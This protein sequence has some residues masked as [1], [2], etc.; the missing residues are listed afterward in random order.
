M[1]TY[2]V[3]QLFRR[4]QTPFHLMGYPLYVMALRKNYAAHNYYAD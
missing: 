1:G 3:Q 4:L 2:G